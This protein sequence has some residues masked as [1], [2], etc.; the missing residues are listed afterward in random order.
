MGKKNPGE[1]KSKAAEDAEFNALLKQLTTKSE[2]DSP[3]EPVVTKAEAK[4]SR[5]KKALDLKQAKEEEKAEADLTNKLSR[6]RQQQH[7]AEI[8]RA[9]QS[10]NFGGLGQDEVPWLDGAPVMTKTPE[11]QEDADV[12]VAVCE[13]QGWRRKMEDAQILNLTM[14]N[15]AK[16]F[17]V[18][19]GHVGRQSADRLASTMAERLMSQPA[20][21]AEDYPLAF[22]KAYI[23]ADEDLRNPEVSQNSGST[24]CS[25]LLTTRQKSLVCANVGDSRAVLCREGRAIDLSRDHKPELAEESAR[26]KAAGGYVEGNR[27]NGGLAMSRAMGDFSYKQNSALPIEKQQVICIPEV[28]ETMLQQGDEFFIV[29]CDGVWDVL[30]SQEACDV[31][32]RQLADGKSLLEITA[33]ICDACCCPSDGA[34]RPSRPLG[35]DNVTVQVVVFREAFKAQL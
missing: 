2:R 8:M 23:A 31:V 32:R 18:F 22:T 27:V 26:I 25:V 29:G 34:G 14:R 5:Q 13:M 11:A 21:T 16:L 7:M 24:A 28:T 35:T 17:A 10:G 15:N 30:S 4:K 9:I 12:S 1:K 33:N 19:D 3:Q 20:Y 6:Q